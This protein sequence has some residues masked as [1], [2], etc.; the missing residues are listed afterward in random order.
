MNSQ[1]P[2][3]I[4]T[5][6]DRNVTYTLS[7]GSEASGY[8]SPINKNSTNGLVLIQEW[9]GLN[10]SIIKTADIL[11]EQGFSV[12]CPD[13]YRGKQAIDRE[14]AEHLADGLDWSDAVHVIGGAANYLLSKGYKKIGVAG[15]CMGGALSIAA[16]CFW[17][18]L[19]SACAPFYG[20]PD[21]NACNAKKIACPIY[22]NF[23][24]LDD[25][26]GF[27][28]PESARD[29]EKKLKEAGADVRIKI[30]EKAGHGFMNQDSP[31]YRKEV[32]LLA[33]EELLEFLKK[34]L[35]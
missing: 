10:K 9:W 1:L 14:T 8:H 23:A 25:V 2:E 22:L 13:I 21:M 28:D 34:N 20:I 17:G 18:K 26:K 32:A 30:W 11:A 6:G 24:E 3:P 27:S 19:F 7:V 16:V 35:D 12:L 31:N 33:Q 4:I 15:F 5:P 29:L